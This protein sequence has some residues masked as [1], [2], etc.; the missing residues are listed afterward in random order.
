MTTDLTSTTYE[1]FDIGRVISRAFGVIRRNFGMIAGLA[2]LLSGLPTGLLAVAQSG[3]VPALGWMTAGLSWSWLLNMLI[4]AWLQAAVIRGAI[5][6]LNGDRPTFGVC[7]GTATGDIL[8]LLGISVTAT[9]AIA[10]GAIF[11]IVPGV[12]LALILSVSAPVRVIERTG[13]FAALARSGDLTRNHRGSILGLFLL[14]GL[15]N[16]MIGVV[17]NLE[18]ELLSLTGTT[19]AILS[20]IVI[21]PLTGALTA[22]IGATGIAAIYFELRT[23][24]EGIGIEALAAAFD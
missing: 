19:S 21:A 23:V 2:L 18:F 16:V 20:D 14:Y 4:G 13:V 17:G 5:T 15:G 7:L 12:I 11:F 1:R 22:L 10:L 8:P 3:V 9:I 6:D 24:K